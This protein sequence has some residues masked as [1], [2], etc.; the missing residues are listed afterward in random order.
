[1]HPDEGIIS[2]YAAIVHGLQLRVP[3]PIPFTAVSLKTVRVQNKDFTF[4]PK[5]YKVDDSL[6]LTEI[7]ALYIVF[8]LKY[9]GVNLLVFSALAKHYNEDELARLVSIEP[10]GQYSR[11]IWFIVEWLLEKKLTAIPDLNKK[12][13]LMP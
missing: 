5:S 2:G 12:V 4:L 7:E 10:T 11:R 8:A 9:E 1:M 6:E 3:L 13:M